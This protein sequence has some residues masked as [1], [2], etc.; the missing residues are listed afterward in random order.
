M[1]TPTEVRDGTRHFRA[2]C[3]P[4]PAKPHVMPKPVSLISRAV[5]GR[6]ASF[7]QR[8]D[9]GLLMPRSARVGASPVWRAIVVPTVDH[10]R[11]LLSP[12]RAA[13][14]RHAA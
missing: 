3:A 9:C 12:C 11:P 1:T 2:P 8:E 13:A 7:C 6:L 5:P 4:A 14:R 10:R